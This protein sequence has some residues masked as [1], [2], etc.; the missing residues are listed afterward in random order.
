MKNSIQHWTLSIMGC[1]MKK[2]QEEWICAPID[3]SIG[4]SLKGQTGQQSLVA[5]KKGNCTFQ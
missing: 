4:Q 1:K 3:Q 2:K 5:D